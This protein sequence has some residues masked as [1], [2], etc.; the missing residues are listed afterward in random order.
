LAY[1]WRAG[2]GSTLSKLANAITPASAAP[3]FAERSN[4]K[5][6]WNALAGS[7]SDAKLF[8][9]GYE[10]EARF[11]LTAQHT[12]DVLERYAG[13]KSSDIALEIGCGVGRVGN[14]LSRRVSSWIGTDISRNMLAHAAVRLNGLDNCVLK[15]L[16]TVGL[17]EIADQSVDL[18][19]C[20]V[21]LMHL[22]EWDRYRYVVESFRVLKPGG[23]CFFDN[24]D[25]T[26]DHGWEVFSAGYAF[27]VENRPSQL[28]MTSSGDELRVYAEKAGFHDVR[29]HR[30]DNAWV[31]VTGVKP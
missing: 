29:I 5:K 7:Y 2:I 4:Y 12:V 11:E 22:L 21:V 17:R 28:S 6:T 23:R 31:A 15:E 3:T 10:D 20:T 13:I 19:Y 8:V 27:N 1:S 16:G 9:A 24:V 14:V 26:S 25:I 30:W 18:V